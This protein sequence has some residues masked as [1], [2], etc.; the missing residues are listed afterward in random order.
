MFSVRRA[1]VAVAALAPVVTLLGSTPSAPAADPTSGQDAVQLRKASPIVVSAPKTARTGTAIRFAGDV[2]V[3]KKPRAVQLAEKRS[4]RWKVVARTRS[5]RTGSFAFRLPAGTTAATRVFRAQAPAAGGLRGLVT[6]SLKV[7]VTKTSGSS[8]GTGGTGPT[9]PGTDDYDAAEAL[10]NGY[11][12]AGS[13]NDWSSLFGKDSVRWDPC[14]VIT[15]RYNPD[16]EAY[17]AR[18][19]VTRAIAKISGVSGL[20]F[21]YVGTSSFSYRGQN[22]PTF[23]DDADLFVS[24]AS[25]A[26]YDDLQ[27]STVGVGG[28]YATSQGAAAL[29]VDWRMAN[30]YLTLDKGASQVA[31][32]F[33]G[34]GWGQIM[35]HETLHAMGLGHAASDPGSREV[36]APVATSLNYRFGAGDITGMHN[37]GER[38][39][40]GCTW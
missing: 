24:W 35:M 31:S 10:P 36:M 2:V 33:D 26:Q 28:G 7:K 34:S 30:G 8:G 23:P 11:D 37:I 32:G 5:A 25:A 14:T 21:K 9:V 13:K 17:D 22:H 3:A 39:G 27:G 16:G 6:G 40:D 1:L 15:W 20:K 29:D 12:A 4:G 19:D 18:A 38:P